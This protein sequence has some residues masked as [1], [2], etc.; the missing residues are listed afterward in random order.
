M[1]TKM[2]LFFFSMLMIFGMGNVM[3]Q[4]EIAVKN[5]SGQWIAGNWKVLAE[6]PDSISLPY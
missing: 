2:K 5:D 3:G 6:L 4:Y 1:K